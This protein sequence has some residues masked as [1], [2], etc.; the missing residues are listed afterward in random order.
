L[1]QCGDLAQ[2]HLGIAH[3]GALGFASRDE[4]PR[5][6]NRFEGASCRIGAMTLPTLLEEGLS[7][8]QIGQVRRN[9]W[10]LASQPD[11]G[12]NDDKQYNF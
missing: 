4:L 10:N 3:E 12:I 1:P 7:D 11:W 6:L 5:K 2:Q 9:E 8:R